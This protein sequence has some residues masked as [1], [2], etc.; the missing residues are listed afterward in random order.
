[1]TLNNRLRSNVYATY[2][3]AIIACAAIWLACRDQA[4][5]LPPDWFSLFDTDFENVTNAAGQ[6]RRVY[7]IKLDREHLPL[8]TD[9]MYQWL[10]EHK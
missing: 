9:E 7:Y 1:M 5:K 4:I 8:Y 2:D 6:I 10:A 3:P